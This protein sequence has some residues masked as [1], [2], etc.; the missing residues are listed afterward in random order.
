MTSL[1]QR[2][3]TLIDRQALQDS[4]TTYLVAVDD[5]ASVDDI[6]D[7]FT[8][9]AVFDMTGIGYPCIEGST[10]LREFFCGV[11]DSMSHQAH[12]ATNFHI[13]NITANAASCRS[14]VIGKGVTNDANE[15]CFYLQYQL[16]F[17]RSDDSWKI[18]SFS[19]RPLM[20][21]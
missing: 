8:E 5:M 1:E 12:Y 13:D 11:F 18:C 4:L 20:P 6:L 19:G 16:E 9:D 3:Q 17:K 15:V 2:L 14:H 21:I 7:C 10:A